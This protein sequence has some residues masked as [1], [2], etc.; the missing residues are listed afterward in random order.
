MSWPDTTETS[1]VFLPRPSKTFIEYFLT[2]YNN[3]NYVQW[4]GVEYEELSCQNVVQVCYRKLKVNEDNTITI[5]PAKQ[6]WN[7]EE[8]TQ[9]IR[10]AFF[11]NGGRKEDFNTW[12]EQNL[13]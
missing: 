13:I 8:V 12:I 5:K 7:R 9:L 6:S 11:R 2:E 4:V 10:I 1:K 3:K